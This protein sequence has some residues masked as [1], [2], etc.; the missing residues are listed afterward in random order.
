L[1]TVAAPL[2]IHPIAR[3]SNIP[4]LA[5]SRGPTM[6][7]V[8]C[9][10]CSKNLNVPDKFA[11]KRARCPACQGA[12]TIPVMAEEVVEELEVVEEAAPIRPRKPVRSRRADED[13]EGDERIAQKPT[14]RTRSVDDE[15][16]DRPR[17]KKRRKKPLGDWAPCPNCGCTD[18]TRVRWT[19]WGGWFGPM[20]INI[21]CCSDCGK[22]YNGVHGDYNTARIAIFMVVRIG[23][24]LTV[25]AVIIG[26][27]LMVR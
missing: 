16:D 27:G 12:V 1:T 5:F 8:R 20:I 9:P 7:M 14:R 24:G 21:V 22:Y 17:R 15:D 3:G 18:A 26:V 11:G 10:S 13:D 6:V 4:H 23:I 19:F 2:I 25:V